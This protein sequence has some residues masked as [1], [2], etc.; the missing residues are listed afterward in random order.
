MNRAIQSSN[1]WALRLCPSQTPAANSDI[2]P[3]V[4]WANRGEGE[5]RIWVNEETSHDATLNASY[6]YQHIGAVAR[7]HRNAGL[8]ARQY[9]PGS[10]R[11]KPLLLA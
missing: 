6:Q 8:S 9:T 11:Q 4:S 5:M 2:Y 1:R 10:F 3:V 7:H